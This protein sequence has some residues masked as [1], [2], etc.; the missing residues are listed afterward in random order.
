MSNEKTIKA[1]YAEYVD[2][3]VG[4]SPSLTTDKIQRILDN[5]EILEFMKIEP[6]SYN[7]TFSWRHSPFYSTTEKTY[8]KVMQ[9]IAEYSK[10]DISFDWIMPVVE[11]IESILDDN[12]CAMYNV[13][14][15]Q[16]FVEIIQNN[17][18][19]IISDVNNKDTKI[20][21]I[22]AAVIEFIRWYKINK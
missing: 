10:Y 19:D 14:I 4:S 8:E 15:E 3:R 22:Y 6:L 16:C 5:R 2:A 13:N 12:Q 9:N 11:K 20:S 17:T 7:G 21:A 1:T 18:S